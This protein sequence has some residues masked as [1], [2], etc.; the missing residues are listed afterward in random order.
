MQTPRLHNHMK[1]VHPFQAERY[2]R[3]RWHQRHKMPW[4]TRLLIAGA[5]VLAS[6]QAAKWVCTEPAKEV[7]S[8]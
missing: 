6:Y 2:T 4:L 1:P 7:K 5:I 8:K 3:Q